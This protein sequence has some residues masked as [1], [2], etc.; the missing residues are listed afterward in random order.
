MTI[1][2]SID[3][4]VFL[5]TKRYELL[6]AGISLA[7]CEILYSCIC[8]TCLGMEDPYYVWIPRRSWSYDDSMTGEVKIVIYRDLLSLSIEWLQIIRPHSRLNVA[9]SRSRTTKH[10]TNSVRWSTEIW[11]ASSP[12][13]SGWRVVNRLVCKIKIMVYWFNF[14]VLLSFIEFNVAFVSSGK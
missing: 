13:G 8:C 3:T 7:G 12:N 9:H 14:F 11:D 4:S 1:F 5:F 6:P 2:L 10:Y